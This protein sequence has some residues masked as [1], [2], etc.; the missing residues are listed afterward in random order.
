MANDLNFDELDK[1][2]HNY[3]QKDAPTPAAVPSTP[4]APAASTSPAPVAT[5]TPVPAAPAPV[6]PAPVSQ[7]PASRPAPPAARLQVKNRQTIAPPRGSGTTFHDIVSP[8]RTMAV[9]SKQLTP[10]NDVTSPLH[11]QTAPKPL[12][13]IPP[14]PAEPSVPATPPTPPAPAPAPAPTTVATPVP[15]V[16]KQTSLADEEPP[17]ATSQAEL[18]RNATSNAAPAS[19]TTDPTAIAANELSAALR[20]DLGKA[21]D[22]EPNDEPETPVPA[23]TSAPQN[24]AGMAYNGGSFGAATTPKQSTLSQTGGSIH[25]NLLDP[26]DISSEPLLPSG[27]EGQKP[28]QLFDTT[29]YH[30]PINDGESLKT[31]DSGKKTLAMVI[32]LVALCIVVAAGVVIYMMYIKG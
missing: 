16:S 17:I 14:K 19:D 31:L 23:P 15:E 18:L 26:G 27:E 13:V 30:T 4:S 2:V 28:M 8:R 10:M 11:P 6:V 24:N 32:G 7:A 9:P 21:A 25:E 12:D 22:N 20:E 5:P 1:A 3:M 29:Q